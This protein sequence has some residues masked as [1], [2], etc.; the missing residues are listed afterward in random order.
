MVLFQDGNTASSMSF[1][2]ASQIMAYLFDLRI[3]QALLSRTAVLE[4]F[5]DADAAPFENIA[6]C[7]HYASGLSQQQIEGVGGSGGADHNAIRSF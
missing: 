3:S 7:A 2:I 1:Q 4:S 6:Q 5:D